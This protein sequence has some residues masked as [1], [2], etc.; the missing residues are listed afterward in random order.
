[1]AAIKKHLALHARMSK[2]AKL[3]NRVVLYNNFMTIQW[4][5]DYSVLYKNLKF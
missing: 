2:Q 5:A 3:H 1:M 4:Y